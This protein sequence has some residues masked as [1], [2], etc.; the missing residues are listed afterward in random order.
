MKGHMQNSKKGQMIS[1]EGLVGLLVVAAIMLIVGAYV[2]YT[3]GA[4]FVPSGSTNVLLNNT[5]GNVTMMFAQV[6]PLLVIVGIV[7]F[8]VII[9]AFVSLLRQNTG[10][11]TA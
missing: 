11:R 7:G 9:L 8:V 3:I 2:V 10:G 5:V 4:A 1:I 6:A